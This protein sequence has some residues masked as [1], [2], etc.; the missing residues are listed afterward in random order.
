MT[1]WWAVEN[2]ELWGFAGRIQ[3]SA[4]LP[5]SCPK[6]LC[7]DLITCIIPDSSVEIL[8][9]WVEVLR[10]ESFG[11]FGHDSRVLFISINAQE[12][13]WK[14]NNAAHSA[15]PKWGSSAKHILQIRF[16]IH[17]CLDAGLSGIPNYKKQIPVWKSLHLWCFVTLKQ[18]LRKIP[19][20]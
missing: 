20:C 11:W 2:Q 18:Q 16:W 7:G 12:R 10:H 8:T 9:L 14:R 1:S 5:A 13:L 6:A 19:C 3:F 15:L 4:H 17:Q